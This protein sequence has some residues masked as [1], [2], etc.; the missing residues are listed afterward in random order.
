MPDS[1]DKQPGGEQRQEQKTPSQ[2]RWKRGY[3]FVEHAV[4]V[5]LTGAMII[6]L[7]GGMC[8]EVFLRWA[9]NDSM[10]GLPEVV[11]TLVVMM[12]FLALAEVQRVDSHIKMDVIIEKLKKRRIG[13]ILRLF[14]SIAIAAIC[15][16]IAY[17]LADYTILAYKAGHVTMNIFMPRW[18]TYFVSTV[19][20]VFM[21]IRICV[22]MKNIIDGLKNWKEI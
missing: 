12:T 16:L 8:I 19:G 7:I 21:L 3:D 2:G 9:L 10:I 15:A 1:S 6:F 18:P 14:N 5:Y 22:E 17:V 11:E 13:K 20:T 4:S